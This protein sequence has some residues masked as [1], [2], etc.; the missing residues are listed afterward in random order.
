LPSN[1]LLFYLLHAAPLPL[2]TPWLVNLTKSFTPP[3]NPSSTRTRALLG[4]E[5][6]FGFFF[7][8]H[9]C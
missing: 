4:G 9:S 6:H 3:M 2:L 7:L 1:L 8:Q 5:R